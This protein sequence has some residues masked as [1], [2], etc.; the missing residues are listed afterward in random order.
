MEQIIDI[1]NE[2]GLETVIIA[3]LINL[4]TGLI[5]MPIKAW[6]KK[7][8]DSTKITRFIVFMPVLFGLGLTFCYAKFV[9][10]NYAFDKEFI[11]LWLTASSLS[12]TFY[13]IFEK[14]FPSKTKLLE[15]CEIETSEKI[16][17]NIKQLMEKFLSQ[18]TPEENEENQEN[19]PEAQTESVEV[20]TDKIILRGKI[21]EEN[22]ITA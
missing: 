12:L 6:A 13:A 7:F 18:E 3:L 15:N 1:I 20:K 5:K 21:N 16:L 22:E 17:E 9:V 19:A 8:E 4:L 11:T 10:G 2:Y 14:I